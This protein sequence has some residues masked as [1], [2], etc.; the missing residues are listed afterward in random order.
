[1]SIDA[2]LVVV[3]TL[4]APQL[5]LNYMVLALLSGTQS[6]ETLSHPPVFI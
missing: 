6:V 4:C 1:M 2:H 5:M 3:D